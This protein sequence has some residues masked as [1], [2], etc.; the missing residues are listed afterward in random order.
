MDAH[1]THAIDAAGSHDPGPATYFKIGLVLFVLTGL[2]VAAYELAH[3]GGT[4]EQILGPVVVPVLLVLS[5]LKFGLVAA[6]YM[7]LKND[8]KAFTGLFVSGL[9]IAAIV[10][11]TLM[12]LMS[13]H[14]TY[15][16]GQV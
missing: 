11:V 2:E 6:Y 15:N 9:I 4:A 10:I 8:H 7:H 3:R 14:L 5:A 13:Y 12:L 16:Q 1:A